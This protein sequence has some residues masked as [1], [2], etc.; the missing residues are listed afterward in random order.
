M[1]RRL[2]PLLTIVFLICACDPLAPV[3]T[4]TAQVIIVTPEDTATP[5]NTATTPPTQTPVP[6]PTPQDTATPTP[7]PCLPDG[8]QIIAYD[9]FRTLSRLHPA[10]LRRDEQALPL[11]HPA[12]RLAGE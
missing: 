11:R 1:T 7:L 5:V 9:D 2:L 8:G 6:S 3:I 10:V 12:A 4:P